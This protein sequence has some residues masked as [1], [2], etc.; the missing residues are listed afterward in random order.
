[1]AFLYS[2]NKVPSSAKPATG[3]WLIRDDELLLDIP[4]HKLENVLLFGNVQVTSQAMV[5]CSKREFTSVS[6]RL[7]ALYRGALAP[8]RCKNIDLR[9]AQFESFRTI[10]IALDM[11]RAAVSTK[12]ANGAAVLNVRLNPL[13]SN[14][15]SRP[16][17]RD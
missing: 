4:C 14:D 8:P 16:P 10:S 5:N 3:C 17:A 15:W 7:R 2:P 1:V 6:F 11:A 13:E 12:I 9:I